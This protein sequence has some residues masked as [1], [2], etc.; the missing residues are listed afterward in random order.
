LFQFFAS[1]IK[2]TIDQVINGNFPGDFIVLSKK[3]QADPVGAI[4]PNG[5]ADDVKVLP[6]VG[7]V[8]RLKY[9]FLKINGNKTLIVAI[10][11]TTFNDVFDVKPIDNY[12]NLTENTVYIKEDILKSMNKKIGDSIKVEYPKTGQGEL[13]ITGTFK[14]TFDSPY[15]ISDTT[16][17][18]N[19]YND[20]DLYFVANLREGLDHT[21][22]KEA[23]KN[24]LKKY[25]LLQVQDKGELVE[26]TKTQINQVLALMGALL[27]F[28][29][30]IAVLGITN[31]LTLSVSERTREIGML[32]AIGMT[33]PEVRKMIRSEAVIIAL[34]GAI[35]GIIM[36]IFFSWAILKSLE[37]I[38]FS[39]FSIPIIQLLGYLVLSAVAGVIAA[40]LPS[41]R[42]SK[43][44]ILDAI[45][46]Q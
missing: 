22:G 33:R 10:E 38:G 21:K 15:F 27:G 34:F 1:S 46:Y 19:F 11:P 28:A 39:V 45:N 30:I 17:R 43:M 4:L 32:R 3:Q 41:Y 23:I 25:P 24:E 16:Y 26:Q 13:K 18:N 31:T 5:V 2:A 42:A 12:T 8:S 29:I 44:N 7:L 6:E 36:G 35:L 20:K 37:D 14:D 40:I 9:D